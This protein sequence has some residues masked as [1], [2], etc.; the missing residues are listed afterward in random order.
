[1]SR[2]WTGWRRYHASNTIRAVC[3][4]VLIL[5]KTFACAAGPCFECIRGRGSLPESTCYLPL[6]L[7]GSNHR[8]ETGSVVL[9]LRWRRHRRLNS[10]WCRGDRRRRSELRGLRRRYWRCR[11]HRR[12]CWEG[13]G[14]VQLARLA[15]YHGFSTPVARYAP[16]A[17]SPVAKV[18][19]LAASCVTVR[20]VAKC[21]GIGSPCGVLARRHPLSAAW[22]HH[23]LP[24][25]TRA[26]QRC[27]YEIS[28]GLL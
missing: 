21:A 9:R 22:R 3:V 11:L 26:H 5:T 2:R 28:I 18:W 14:E 24:A 10:S 16:V 15:G 23:R 7:L 12:T 13:S 8:T 4:L 19:P 1:M 20:P 6:R 17:D 25:H 27:R